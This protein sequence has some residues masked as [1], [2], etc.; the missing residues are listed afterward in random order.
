MRILIHVPIVVIIT[1][2]QNLTLPSVPFLYIAETLRKYPP[3]P[4]LT[5]ECTKGYTIPGTDVT[6]EK[7]MLVV[8]PVL[9][10]HKDP[11]YYP[12]PEKFDPDRFRVEAKS[13]RHHFTYLPFGEGPRV[14]IGKLL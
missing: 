13:K 12:N 8:I 1:S 3:V 9:G 14:C 6:L 10:I 4:F 5:R 2:V 7:G 11:K